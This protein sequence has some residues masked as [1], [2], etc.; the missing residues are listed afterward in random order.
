M[1]KLPEPFARAI[2]DLATELAETMTEANVASTALGAAE[3][4]RDK[5]ARRLAALASERDA[6]VS[7]RGAGRHDQNDGA[8]LALIQAD[9]EGLHPLLQEAVAHV[10]AAQAAYSAVAGNASRFRAQIAQ[11]EAEAVRDALVRHAEDVSLKLLDTVNALGEACRRSGYTGRPIWGAPPA[12]YQ[13][14]RS[15]AAQRGEL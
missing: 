4:Q 2:E 12:L 8:S 1:T 9:T 15:L 10:A 5:I 3:E 14:L 13:A 6:I 7:R 11:V